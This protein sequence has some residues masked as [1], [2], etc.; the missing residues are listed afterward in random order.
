MSSA[1]PNAWPHVSPANKDNSSRWCPKG[2]H[3][4]SR[5]PT[6]RRPLQ[7]ISM[8]YKKS[9]YEHGSIWLANSMPEH[10]DP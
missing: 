4:Q 3:L 5:N 6:P 2:A 8:A 1:V 9:E 7:P 10:V